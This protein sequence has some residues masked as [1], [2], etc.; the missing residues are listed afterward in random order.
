MAALILLAVLLTAWPALADP[1]SIGTV[2]ITAATTY[3]T[4][5]AGSAA[6]SFAITVAGAAATLALRMAFAPSAP[7]PPQL[8][9]ELAQ[10]NSISPR[11]YA[12]GRTKVMGLPAPWIVEGSILYGC[13]ILNSRRSAGGSVSIT[14]DKQPVELSGDPYSFDGAGATATDSVFSGYLTAW[15]GRG[16]QTTP[17]A[18]I[19]SETGLFSST[20]AWAGATVLWLR[21]DAGPNRSRAERWRRVPPEVEVIGDWSTVWDPRDPSQN[22]D[23]ETTWAFSRNRA[24][25]VLDALMRNPARPYPLNQIDIDSFSAAADVDDEP[26]LLKEGGTEP[27]YRADGLVAWSGGE[28]HAL[29]QPIIDAGASELV[30]IGGRIALASG[31]WSAPTVTVEDF[32]GDEL[33]YELLRPGRDFATVWA[34][35]YVSPDRDYEM[36]DLPPYRISGPAA[37][38]G[39]ELF[40]VTS[41][42][43]A[44]RVQKIRA[45]RQAR[46]QTLRSTLPPS[47]AELVTS[48]TATLSLP[49]PYAAAL[50]GT[51]EVRRI[52]PV[53]SLSGDG[54]G[55]RCPADLVAT[56]P[57]IYS[58]DPDIDEVDIEAGVDVTVE[59]PP[60]AA[61]TGVSIT[62]TSGDALSTGAFSL[63]RVLVSWSPSSSA[64]VVGYEVQQRVDAGNWEPVGFVDEGVRDESGDVYAYISPATAGASYEARV[65]SVAPGAAS[66]WAEAG[67]TTAS[68]PT[69]TVGAPDNG[70]ATGGAGQ[71]A[72]SFDAP[73]DAEFRGIEFLGAN[74]NSFAAAS[75]IGD[76][77]YGPPNVA[78]G[79]SE[80]GLGT[81]V[82]RHYWA[83]SVDAYGQVGA[84]SAAVSAT[85]DP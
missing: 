37:E 22:A 16:D 10:P 60:P 71:I 77:I 83:R 66:D 79:L 36:A 29:I 61:P 47:A 35:R 74:T 4:A 59:R 6:L 62:S 63:P 42:T 85:T 52:A 53:L 23:D 51:W 14:I 30:R 20:D 45:L 41:A 39:D 82:T 5:A 12:Y 3:G 55:M 31:S 2:L 11:R 15:I 24:L 38:G 40:F 33:S 76:I 58:W 26:V 69:V 84:A 81:S 25:I 56:G 8:I 7:R 17:P 9:R 70:S 34:T 49:E 65:R 44:M 75:R 54:V 21:L 1:V 27:R 50:N 72:I 67:P 46:Q 13:L 64:R 73:N 57:E 48:S 80:T 78:Y 19:L 28:A 43:Q 32:I 68:P 18:A